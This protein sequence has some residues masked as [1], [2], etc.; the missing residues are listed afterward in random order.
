M[1]TVSDQAGVRL[2]YLDEGDPIAQTLFY[3]PL[4]EALAVARQQPEAVQAGLWLA[5][6][7]DVVAFLD[8]ED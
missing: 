8:L 2:Y 3:G 7:N 1:R 5:T 6:D 4:S